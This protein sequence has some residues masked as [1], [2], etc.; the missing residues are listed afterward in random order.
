MNRD[1]GLLLILML[2]LL[3]MSGGRRPPPPNGENGDTNGDTDGDTG[4]DPNGI[5]MLEPTISGGRTWDSSHWANGNSRTLTR[6]RRDPDDPTN[7][8][9]PAGGSSWILRGDGLAIPG[10]T[11]PRMHWDLPGNNKMFTNT[12]F[13]VY[14]RR[15][16]R[17]GPN[18]PGSPGIVMG[19]RSDNHTNSDGSGRCA[20]VYYSRFGHD[21]DHVWMKE[22]VHPSVQEDQRTQLWSGGMPRGL[23]VGQKTLVYT[24]SGGNVVLEAYIDLADG[25]N[26]G[27]WRLVK[28]KV[29]NGG[30]RTARPCLQSSD[31]IIREIGFCYIRNDDHDPN[32]PAAYKWVSI[33]EIRPPE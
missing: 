26:G 20:H 23:W 28:R 9:R 10:D 1:R 3:S 30:W 16:A 21:G 4:R 5:T 18:T 19:H 29:D 7:M 2:V 13:T 31:F 12:E 25:Q 24:R 27:D 33:R 22:L 11:A 17:D 32:N 8:M 14:Y 15:G 6:R